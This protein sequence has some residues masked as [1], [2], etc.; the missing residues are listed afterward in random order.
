MMPVIVF[1]VV[2]MAR[3]GHLRIRLDCG[4]ITLRLIQQRI[5]GARRRNVHRVRRRLADRRLLDGLLL[6]GS[7]GSGRADGGRLAL[8]QTLAFLNLSPLGFR[9]HK[10]VCRSLAAPASATH[11]KK[12]KI[13]E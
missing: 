3:G 13:P 5:V 12:K 6:N 4:Q 10:F 11:T 2:A 9:I 7:A 8:L 1:A